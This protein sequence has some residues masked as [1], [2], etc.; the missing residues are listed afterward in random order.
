MSATLHTSLVVLHH[1]EL[2]DSTFSLNPPGY[3]EP[4]QKLIDSISRVGILHPPI[5]QEKDSGGYT[6]IAGNKRLQVAK[7]EL[8]LSSLTCLLVAKDTPLVDGLAIS[9]EDTM[10]RGPLSPI[11]QA[12]FLSKITEQLPHDEAAQRFLPLMGMEPHPQRIKRML[13]LLHLEENL[14]EAVHSGT[15]QEKVA[16]EML[17]MNF[18]DRMAL[19]EVMELIALSVSNQKK[20]VNLCKELAIR[21]QQP[22]LALLSQTEVREILEHPEANIP[23]KAANLMHWLTEQCFPRLSEAE[24]E[25]RKFSAGLNLPKGIRL[26]HAQAFERDSVTLSLPFANKESLAACWPEIAAIIK[27]G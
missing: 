20:L 2:A 8:G 14:Q 19:F 11:E 9:L 1:V 18:T 7:D 27:K 6:V 17:S 10:L 24:K 3:A 21:K 25:F 4:S 5:L 13:E 22:V 15:L 12:I 26:D 23:Q 16:R